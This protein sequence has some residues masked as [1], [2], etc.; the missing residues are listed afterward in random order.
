MGTTAERIEVTRPQAPPGKR[1]DTVKVKGNVIMTKTDKYSWTTVDDEGD[2]RK[3]SKHELN[4]DTTYQRVMVSEQ[5]VL[6]ISA[7][8]SWIAFNALT[9]ADRNGMLW[10]IDGQHRLAAAMR[11]ADIDRLPVL[12]FKSQSAEHEA[13]AFLRANCIRGA[14]RPFDKLRASLVASD[15]IAIDACELMDAEGYEPEANHGSNTVCCISAFLGALKSSRGVLERVWPLIADLHRP[16]P[17]RK[18]V[19][20]ALMYI[21]RYGSRDISGPEWARRVLKRGLP[22]IENEISRVDA[23]TGKGGSRVKYSAIATLN[24]INKGV[25]ENKRIV[26]TIDEQPADDGDDDLED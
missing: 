22:E 11:R 2:L 14:V 1:H 13:R 17:I 4:N 19:F 15:Q 12:V 21:G 5:R 16:L 8:W 24:V 18:K 20:D 25:K 26:L 6:T 3:V 7:E 23:A 10:V 9:V